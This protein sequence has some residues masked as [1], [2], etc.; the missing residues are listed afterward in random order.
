VLRWYICQLAKVYSAFLFS[1]PNAAMDL[2]G[3]EG[4]LGADLS[5]PESPQGGRAAGLASTLT[6]S[7]DQ[8]AWPLLV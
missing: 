3:H 5:V 4:S 2:Q 6:V 7:H 8:S 1:R